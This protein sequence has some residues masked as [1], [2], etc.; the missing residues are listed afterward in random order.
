MAL[1][2]GGIIYTPSPDLTTQ[3]GL[4]ETVIV[5]TPPQTFDQLT[6][7]ESKAR[8]TGIIKITLSVGSSLAY[9]AGKGSH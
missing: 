4:P 9:R 1:M 8:L 7:S 5:A 2:S 3:L 6:P